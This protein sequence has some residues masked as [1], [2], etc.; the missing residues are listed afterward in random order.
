MSQAL[1]ET[2]EVTIMG[3]PYKCPYCGKSESVAKGRRR[4]KTMGDR[5]IRRCRA[6]HRKFTPR[7][8]KPME[9]G[10]STDESLPRHPKSGTAGMAAAGAAGPSGQDMRDR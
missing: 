9:P 1:G 2:H 3:R 7:N 8:Q 4:T 5:C 6:C 10:I